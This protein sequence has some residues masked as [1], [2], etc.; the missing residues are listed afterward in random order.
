MTR[1]EVRKRIT[2]S[3]SRIGAAIFIWVKT[4]GRRAV[5]AK[6]Y[7]FSTTLH[8]E[9]A[10]I[11]FEEGESVSQASEPRRGN[12]RSGVIDAIKFIDQV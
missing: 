2:D 6:A 9:S 3:L 4:A 12:G 10:L 7:W 11:A 8:S 1:R 5:V